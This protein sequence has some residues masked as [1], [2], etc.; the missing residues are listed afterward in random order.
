MEPK[1]TL[2]A[3]LNAIAVG[4][5]TGVNRLLE[6][7]PD[8][9][10]EAY[11]GGATTRDASA[12][13]LTA[14]RHYVYDG[15]TALHIAAAA[16]RPEVVVQLIGLGSDVEARNRRGAGPLH[17]AA[18]SRPGASA[19]NPEAQAQT[20]LV[21]A[22]AGANLNA[23]DKSGVA[24]IHRAVRSRGAA[25]VT[26]LLE[27]GADPKLKNGSGSTPADLAAQNTGK[28]GSGSEEAKTEQRA[29]IALLARHGAGR[30]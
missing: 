1:P 27:C 18:D 17:Y 22:K 23:K 16:H 29:I 20:I 4:D 10:G 19:W 5:F 28:S 25:A 14:I 2:R 9:A 26:A 8:L 6:T 15:D 3:L 12:N 30:T 11:T 24:P 21:L 7:S 13:F